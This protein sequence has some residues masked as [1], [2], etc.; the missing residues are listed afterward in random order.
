MQN[1]RNL[2]KNIKIIEQKGNLEKVI[3]G[4][5]FDSRQVIENELFVALSGETVDG[6][7]YIRKAIANGANTIV[8]ERL[9]EILDKKITY[10][11]V[12]NT[13]LALGWLS[14]NFYDNP[15]EKLKLVGI[16]GTNGKTTT[17]TLLYKLFKELG[18]KTGLISTVRNYIDEEVYEAKFTTPYPPD[19][20]K[21]MA[22]MLKKGVTHCFM[23]VSS[24]AIEQDR[25]TGLEFDGAVFTNISHDHLDYHKTFENYIKAKK[26]FFDN[27]P[28]SA[29]A[30][31]N[32]DDKRGKIMLQNTRAK[33]QKTFALFNPADFKAKLLENTLQ[34]LFLEIENR[35]AWFRLI[36][37]FNAYNLL[38]A[39]AVTQLLGEPE[40]EI[41]QVLSAL[42][43]AEGRFEQVPS[44]TG[45]TSIVDY[46]HTPDAL[47][48][49]LKTIQDVLNGEEEVITVVGCGGN[50]DAM[51]RPTMA[52][53]ACDYSN[54]VI[55]TSDNPRDEE[56]IKIIEDMLTGVTPENQHKVEVLENRKEAIFKACQIAK[57]GD[58]I[59][60]AGKGHET[61]Q[62]IKG[63]RHS[64]D[65]RKILAEALQNTFHNKK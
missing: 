29:F 1:L 4:V 61:Y 54:Q 22:E 25:I 14:A 20:Q 24:H 59:L 23:E 13:R 30:L 18:Y 55:L 5:Q 16:T 48:N 57:K 34:G 27:I 64:F 46:S 28:A 63:V 49:A 6:H 40:E 39:Y 21:L 11:K 26:K 47:E 2:F 15:S 37:E 65:D 7:Q 36:G 17:T 50:R 35:Q 51:K 10:L 58:V 32:V 62:E 12:E 33:T 8:C 19:L 45:I 60:V 44:K 9:P 3:Q 38:T 41:L 31:V 43:P 52:K 53:I 56:P 42:K